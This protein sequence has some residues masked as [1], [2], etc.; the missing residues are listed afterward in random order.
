MIYDTLV[1]G[2]GPAGLSTALGLARQLYSVVVFD[3]QKY[4]NHPISHMHNVLTWDHKSPVDFRASARANILSRYDG[5]VFRESR[6]DNIVKLEDDTFEVTDERGDKT[7]GRKVVLATGV[8]DVMMEIEG[9]EELWGRSIFHCLFCHGY[10][11]AGGQ[12]A[13]ILAAGAVSDPQR[14]LHVAGMVAPLARD[15]VVYSNG[16]AVVTEA[17]RAA[18][19]DRRVTIEPRRIVSLKRKDP[20]HAEITVRFQD[21]DTRTE[22]FLVAAPATKLNGPFAAQLGLEVDAQEN[23]VTKPPF[24][25]SSVSGVF[26]VGDCAT[27]IKSVAQAMAM[28]SFAAAGVVGQLGQG[29]F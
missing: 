6:I 16:D 12:S 22:T 15:I 21:G 26:A 9:F 13:G 4:R 8:S 1:L 18:A 24:Y 20:N 3:S 23:I 27:P 5:I 7:V 29:K 25:E 17:I 28:G 10:E 2:A 14:V 11:E 19:K